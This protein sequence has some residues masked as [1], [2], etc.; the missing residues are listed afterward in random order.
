[1]SAVSRR[2]LLTSV[3]VL[4][5]GALPAPIPAA[6]GTDP[7]AFIN[8]LVKQ[9]QAV[10]SCTSPQQKLAGFRELF[11]E[12]FDIPGLGR[13]RPILADFHPVRAAGIPGAVREF[14][15]AHL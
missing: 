2:F 4:I 3:V 15:R 8:D 9:L 6:A 1:M 12:D 7:V 14:R 5:T 10:S 11:R 13:F